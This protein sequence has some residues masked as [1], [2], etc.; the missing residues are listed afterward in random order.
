LGEFE[1][2]HTDRLGRCAFHPMGDYLASTGWDRVWCLYDLEKRKCLL[3]QEGHS[4]RVHSLAFH[5]DGSLIA[6]GDLGGVGRV[7]D[8][9]SGRAI[10]GLDSHVKGILDMD[11]SPNGFVIA[12]AGEDHTIKLWDIRKKR[13]HTVS[14]HLNTV[15]CVK[16]EPRKGDW[17]VT[18]SFD[19]SLKLWTYHHYLNCNE[20]IGHESR[21]SDLDISSDGQ[22]IISCG[23][24]Q[25][26]KLWNCDDVFFSSKPISTPSQSIFIKQEPL[27]ETMLG[28]S[29]S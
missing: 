11:F 12:T 5:P 2:V 14:A 20:L 27:E 24:D 13:D 22:I 26:W 15:T 16:F 7:W 23:H 3:T 6:T 10:M 29:N 21:I 19:K 4:E 28:N 1:K 25:T 8:C 17:F 9:R 18:G